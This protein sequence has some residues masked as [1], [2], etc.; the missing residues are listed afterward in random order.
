[1]ISGFV[2]VRKEGRFEMTDK[3]IARELFESNLFKLCFILILLLLV[4]RVLLGIFIVELSYG[5][6]LQICLTLIPT[7][8]MAVIVVKICVRRYRKTKQKCKWAKLIGAIIFMYIGLILCSVYI[9]HISLG[10]SLLFVPVLLLPAF[11]AL[12]LTPQK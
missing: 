5:I 11:Y 7:I 4:A 1:V 8:I 2:D 10:Y 6:A 12:T 3:S 9:A